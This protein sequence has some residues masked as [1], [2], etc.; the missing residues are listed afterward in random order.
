VTVV[1]AVLTGIAVLQVIDRSGLGGGRIVSIAPIV[2]GLCAISVL[3][4]ELFAGLLG[5]RE[6]LKPLPRLVD[7]FVTILFGGALLA[8]A[9]RVNDPSFAW[10]LA[11]PLVVYAGWLF[12]VFA[13]RHA[14]GAADAANGLIQDRMIATALSG[15]IAGVVWSLH[16]GLGLKLWV[17][18]AVFAV[19]AF[20]DLR[21]EA[22]LLREG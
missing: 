10:W 20:L 9:S 7:A 18:L 1:L 14:A 15:I 22:R 8:A 4:R 5:I 16:I 17:L 11:W 2:A 19:A 6:S 13:L 3:A 21:A 12:V